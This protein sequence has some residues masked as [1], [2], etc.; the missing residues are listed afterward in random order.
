MFENGKGFLN[1]VPNRPDNCFFL[2]SNFLSPRGE[3]K[4]DSN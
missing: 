4:G 1:I 2:I 3:G